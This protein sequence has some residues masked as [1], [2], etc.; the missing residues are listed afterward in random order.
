MTPG[1]EYSISLSKHDYKVL[2]RRVRQYHSLVEQY[3]NRPAEWSDDYYQSVESVV[4]GIAEAYNRCSVTEQNIIKLS[5]WQDE[6]QSDDTIAKI[7]NRS[8]LTLRVFRE[9]ILRMVAVHSH[10]IW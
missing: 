1:T 3:Q 2:E 9:K 8:E 10:Y 6:K 4:K 7:L 5:W